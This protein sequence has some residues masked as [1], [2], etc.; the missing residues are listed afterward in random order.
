MQ[1]RPLAAWVAVL[2]AVPARA[3]K[4]LEA[5]VRLSTPTAGTVTIPTAT[6]DS[7]EDIEPYLENLRARLTQAFAEHDAVVVKG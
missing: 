6:L 4:A 2:D 5:A 1:D 3:A 7:V